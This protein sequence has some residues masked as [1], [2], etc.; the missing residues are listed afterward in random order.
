MTV[1]ISSTNPAAIP[2]SSPAMYNQVVC[3]HLSSP[4]PINHPAAVAAGRMN[5][6]WL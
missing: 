3:S 2:K 6:S 1:L 4:A 5:A